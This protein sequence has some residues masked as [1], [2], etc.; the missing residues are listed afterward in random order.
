V[1][2]TVHALY[3]NSVIHNYTIN[4]VAPLERDSVG[5]ISTYLKNERSAS[6]MKLDKED[7]R[8][9]R[10]FAEPSEVEVK[11]EVLEDIT[12]KILNPKSG[13]YG[14]TT[15]TWSFTI[16]GTKRVIKAR[17]VDQEFLTRYSNGSI[18]FY[19]GDR[20]RVR[21]IERQIVEGAQARMEYEIEKVIEYSQSRTT[22]R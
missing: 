12:T 7:A 14:Q 20:L 10:A 13:N 15:G 21:L 4:I 22:P 2:S 19:Q 9:V 11:V 18:R 3:N 17:I 6:E 1:N 5:S 16:A 8:A